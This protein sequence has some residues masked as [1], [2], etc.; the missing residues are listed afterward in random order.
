MRALVPFFVVVAACSPK[1]TPDGG[2]DSGACMDAGTGYPSGPY[3]TTPR[4]GSVAGD[5]IQNF[6]FQGYAN[7]DP[8]TK[9]MMGALAPIKLGD[10]YDPK[11]TKNRLLVII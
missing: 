11:A 5:R 9:T 3:G 8:K 6:T 4:S 10:F 7:A 1:A 2:T